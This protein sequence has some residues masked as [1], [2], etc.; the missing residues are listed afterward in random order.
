MKRI[1]LLFVLA[2]VGF[3]KNPAAP[4]APV[5]SDEIQMAWRSA[6]VDA[7]IAQAQVDVAQAK[8][9]LLKLRKLQA[10]ETAKVRAVCGDKFEA[11][12]PS[13]EAALVC[14]PKK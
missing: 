2:I 1:A 9:E 12:I 11:I 13:P 8:L 3:A 14:V 5:I 7:D 4:L 6:V 10:Q